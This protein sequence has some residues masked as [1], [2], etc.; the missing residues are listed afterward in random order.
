MMNLL[1]LVLAA[2]RL[3]LADGN[4]LLQ[5]PVFG[6]GQFDGGA[7]GGSA[8]RCVEI[9]DNMTLCRGITYREMTL[10]NLLQHH[11]MHE[12]SQQ[13]AS[14]VPLLNLRCHEDTQ[15]FLCSL[16]APVCLDRLI[17]PCRSLCEAVQQ[18]CEQ[19][20]LNYGFPWPKMLEC[21]QFPHDNDMCIPP[22]AQGRPQTASSDSSAAST[23][24]SGIC[25][26]CNQASTYEN[27]LDNFCRADFAMKT[28]IKERK[29]GELICKKPRIFKSLRFSREERGSP[30]ISL[31]GARRG[32]GQQGG[33]QPEG[34]A[35]VVSGRNVLGGERVEEGV[36]E[37]CCGGL[38][39]EAE[40]KR[41]GQRYLIMGKKDGARLLPTFILPWNRNDHGIHGVPMAS[42]GSVTHGDA[43][44]RGALGLGGRCAHLRTCV[45]QDGVRNERNSR[46]HRDVPKNN[47]LSIAR[48]SD[49]KIVSRSSHSVSYVFSV[50]E[51]RKA[52]R[53]FRGLDC[54]KPGL[55]SRS[56]QIQPSKSSR[57]GKARGRRR[58]S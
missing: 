51:L 40:G 25:K 45:T 16:F 54:T 57:K 29:N 34:E 46:V 58:K 43:G 52:V 11:S 31:D 23:A 7:L 19:R 32:G 47:Q 38:L 28:K 44:F 5:W 56:L 24:D 30:R 37:D 50:K 4:E 48:E 39:E 42:E 9:P 41:K 14:W 26:A 17:Y 20:M 6:I 36:E 21:S 1:V 2:S 35:V 10:P 22:Q 53:M 18:G 8:R 27:I 3:A 49:V 55:M 15:V 33:D 13:A 12:V